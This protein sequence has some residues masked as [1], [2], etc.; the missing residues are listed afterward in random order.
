MT[1]DW[2]ETHP[3]RAANPDAQRIWSFPA[4]AARDDCPRLAK[5]I[6]RLPKGDGK[7]AVQLIAARFRLIEE[8]TRYRDCA[9]H[10]LCADLRAAGC[11]EHEGLAA[12][13]PCRNDLMTWTDNMQGQV[14]PHPFELEPDRMPVAKP[15]PGEERVKLLKLLSA[16][17][18]RRVRLA[19]S[20]VHS[21]A[22]DSR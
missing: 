13:R 17:G 11:R 6:K 7:L 4:T 3:G 5:Q 18:N 21:L 16:C 22:A 2:F 12:D 20:I 8:I 1:E 19:R 14:I 9:I 15:F 10:D